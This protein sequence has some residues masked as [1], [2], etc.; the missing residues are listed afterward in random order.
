MMWVACDDIA[1]QHMAS[2]ADGDARVGLNLLELAV[3]LARSSHF[4]TTGEVRTSV[5]VSIDHVRRSLQRTHL[6]YD[7]SGEQHCMITI[8]S[9]LPSLLRISLTLTL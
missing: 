5:K 4:M 7:K 6:Q 8:F 3:E 2:I 9:Y 1:L